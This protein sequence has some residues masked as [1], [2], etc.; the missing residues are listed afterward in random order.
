MWEIRCG[1][2]GKL[3]ITEF[4]TKLVGARLQ[5]NESFEVGFAYWPGRGRDAVVDSGYAEGPIN[6]VLSWVTDGSVYEE[7]LLEYLVMVSTY[8]SSCRVLST[9]TQAL[10]DML[11]MR[12]AYCDNGGP[13]LPYMEEAP[14]PDMLVTLYRLVFVIGASGGRACGFGTFRLAV[15]APT[16]LT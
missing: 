16:L 8:A 3:G 5:V 14:I 4:E 1:R 7:C 2:V 13:C 6:R 12:G 15:E 11:L 9:H 10:S